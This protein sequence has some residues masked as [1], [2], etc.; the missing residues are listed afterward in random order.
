MSLLDRLLGRSDEGEAR[1]PFR[2]WEY[3]K[4]DDWWRIPEAFLTSVGASFT[5][6]KVVPKRNDDEI[7][8]RAMAGG[9]PFRIVMDVPGY[10]TEIEMR[11]SD[12]PEHAEFDLEFDPQASSENEPQ[13]SDP[14]W[15]EEDEDERRIFL[16]GRIFIDGS[17]AEPEARNFL[18]LPPELRQSILEALES[19]RVMYYRVRSEEIWVS[20]LAD[21][22]EMPDPF[23]RLVKMAELMAS[24]AAAVK[25]TPPARQAKG[26]AISPVRCRYC[27]AWFFLESDPKCRNCAAPYDPPKDG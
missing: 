5:E 25:A 10:D 24:T 8:L 23:A 27:G 22:P 14:V 15:D 2:N 19:E 6:A 11:I 21:P 3:K 17:D 4:E 1:H 12:K 9:F 26:K 13:E 16:A 20:F 18:S 7:E